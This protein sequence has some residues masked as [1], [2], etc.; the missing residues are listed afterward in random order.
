MERH[1]NESQQYSS[2]KKSLM[3]T[4]IAAID[5]E[6]DAVRG[7]TNTRSRLT[8]SEKADLITLY[9]RID[10]LKSILEKLDISGSDWMISQTYSSMEKEEK[11]DD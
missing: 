4:L 11:K 5:N 3:R 10:E 6:M 8:S 1:E 7:V 9:Y 2:R